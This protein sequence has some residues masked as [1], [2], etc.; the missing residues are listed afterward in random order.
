[1][2]WSD[3]VIEALR[4]GMML[5]ERVVGLAKKVERLDQGVPDLDRRLVRIETFVEIAESK[6]QGKLP[7]E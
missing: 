6:R 2:A 5:N 1:M 7:P 3:R 4:T